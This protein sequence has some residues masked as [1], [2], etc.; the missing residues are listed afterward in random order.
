MK[1]G[2]VILCGG[3]SSRMGHDKATL[4]FGSEL[5][6]QRIVRI[7]SLVVDQDSVVVVAAPDQ[8]LPD[9]PPT[10]I[11]ARDERPQRGPLEGLAAGILALPKGV[12]AIY[13]TSCDVPLMVT[14]FVAAMF[15]Y[16]TDHDI[17]VP[18]DG[19]YFH[20]LAAVYRPSVISV[21]QS[22]LSEDQLRPVFLFDKVHAAKI[23]VE[24]LRNVDPTLD[25]LMNLN[26]PEDYHLALQRAGLI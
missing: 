21:I 1:K 3:K 16:L 11:V 24:Q 13:A 10:V 14:G 19:Q 25:T 26:R 20:P 23:P 2:A 22:L 8:C 15:E 17:A 18:F 5:M 9:L 6:L 4:P 12:D 7:V